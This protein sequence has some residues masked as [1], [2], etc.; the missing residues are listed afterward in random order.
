MILLFA[1]AAGL[2]AG[3][4]WA[5]WRGHPYRPPALRYF[6]LVFLAFLP[7]F[8]TIYLPSVREHTPDW[9][10]ATSLI[11]SQTLLLV[12]ALLNRRLPGMPILVAGAV[13]N[14]TVIAANGGFMPISPD[15]AG[16]LVPQEIVQDIGTGSR[17]GTKDILLPPQE[18]RFEWLADRFLTPGWFR[19][20]AAFSLGD[21]FIAIG[22]LWLLA[23]QG[24]P[25]PN[26][27]I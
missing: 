21:V 9:M 22:V 7:Q 5:G 23:Y 4:G 19:Y 24:A 18:T 20:Q 17:F 11:A 8:L 26:R 25:N 13:L 2:L 6:W 3:F 14:L 12:F 1:I 27:G 16:Q 15:T 10:A